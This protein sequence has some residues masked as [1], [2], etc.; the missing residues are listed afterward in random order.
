MPGKIVIDGIAYYSQ[1]MIVAAMVKQS[2]G[3]AYGPGFTVSM[4]ESE[5]DYVDACESIAK[6]INEDC[7]KQFQKEYVKGRFG[8]W[9]GG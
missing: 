5:S 7:F 9:I 8:K 1:D 6:A 2:V 4:A 3:V